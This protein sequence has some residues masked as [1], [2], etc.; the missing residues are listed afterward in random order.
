MFSGLPRANHGN[1]T[2]LNTTGDSDVAANIWP[3]N[4]NAFALRGGSF[5]SESKELQVADRSLS[6]GRY[7]TGRPNVRHEDVT[8]RLGCS[9]EQTTFNSVL[10]LQNGLQ[11][12]EA[13]AADTICSGEDYLIRGDIPDDIEGAYSIIWLY[14]HS[15]S[16]PWFQMK[17]E[18]GRDLRLKNLRNI[19]TV[20][21]N[22]MT[23]CY[24]RCIY[25]SQ[26][27][28][29]SKAAIIKIINT[30]VELSPRDVTVDIV[31]TSSA[32][33]IRSKLPMTVQWQ[34]KGQALKDLSLTVREGKEWQHTPVYN[35]FT[36]SGIVNS[37]RQP[38][39]LYRYF[40]DGFCAGRDTIWANVRSNDANI[41]KSDEVICGNPF[42]DAREGESGNI[43]NT[44]AIGTQCWMADNLNYASSGSKCYQDNDN[45]CRMYGRLY[46]WN[47]ANSACPAG[48]KLPTD[49][50]W[51]T[52][53]N[54][55]GT[56]ATDIKRHDWDEGSNKTGFS[57]LPGGGMF[58]AYSVGTSTNAGINARNGYYD[59]GSRGWWW[60]ST[61]KNHQWSTGYSNSAISM[62]YYIRIDAGLVKNTGTVNS[63][64]TSIFS[65]YY[66]G[67][68][69]SNTS[70][71]TA[72]NNI[73]ANYYF[74]VRCVRTKALQ[75]DEITK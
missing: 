62:P 25:S 6:K 54:A 56:R 39:V 21:N 4:G 73:L 8:F 51:T 41:A 75:P 45:N 27:Y 66:Y 7:E 55:A 29:F 57:A 71:N 46:S 49:D 37:G 9:L 3:I 64:L 11:V 47:Q 31:N 70:N 5:K 38:L 17:G 60:T 36:Y 61:Q 34:F 42:R 44:V 10:T 19:H 32:I 1:G 52:I 43:Y 50:E 15:A 18:H 63:T 22:F 20:E 33:T 72:R 24:K 59:L 69:S 58:Y 26:G 68:I 30:E 14:S 65:S 35:D 13:D 74:S 2:L 12:A 48:W 53:A 40:Y 28:S 16:G 23:Y 67:H